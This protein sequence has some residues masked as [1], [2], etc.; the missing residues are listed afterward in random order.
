MKALWRFLKAR[1]IKFNPVK[2]YVR[3]LP[4][5]INIC[6]NHVIKSCAQA[7]KKYLKFS[8]ISPQG[9]D[10][11][12][13]DIESGDDTDGDNDHDYDDD[14]DNDSDD[15][16]DDGD[17]DDDDDDDDDDND[18]G[19]MNDSD[20]DFDSDYDYDN[21]EDDNPDYHPQRVG[22]VVSQ[23]KKVNSNKKRAGI[24]C[25]PIKRACKLVRFIRSSDRRKL[26]LKEAIKDGN[27]SKYFGYMSKDVLIQVP[28]L[29]LL[30]DIKTCW[31]STY[32][33]IERLLELRPV[34]IWFV[35]SIMFFEYDM[36]G[37]R[38]LFSTASE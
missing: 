26:D 36:A 13:L 22:N 18:I 30:R 9:D 32:A 12:Y 2:N 1:D 10:D 14:N 20:S 24:Q 21:D 27:K 3:C 25:D 5:I 31:D 4:H 8:S 28:D 15:D 6:V 7:S 33:M 23:R 11:Q 16:D 35:V 29:E 34:S 19:N 17:G 38:L 37:Y